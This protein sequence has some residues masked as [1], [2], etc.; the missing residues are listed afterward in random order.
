MAFLIR[1]LGLGKPAEVL[2]IVSRYYPK[3][4]V[5][6]KTRFLVEEILGS[7]SA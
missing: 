1:H 3:G 4:R 5:P 6:A 2:D 7:G